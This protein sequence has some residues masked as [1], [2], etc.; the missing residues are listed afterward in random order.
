MDVL[1]QQSVANGIGES[2]KLV[3]PTRTVD[4]AL[5]QLPPDLQVENDG[6]LRYFPKLPPQLRSRVWYDSTSKRLRLKGRFVETPAGVEE[7]V[8]YLLMNVIS[9][10]E[11]NRLV[12][13]SSDSVFKIAAR[14][15]AAA[16]AQPIEVPPNQVF[17][18]LAVTAGLSKGQGYVTL[19]FANSGLLT[20]NNPAEPISLAIFKVECP[21]YRGELEVIVSENPLEE[22]LTLRHSGD[23]AGKPED[24]VFEWRT[25]PPVD[26]LPPTVPWQQ[27]N[28]FVPPSSGIGVVDI[29]IEGPGLFTLSDNWFI[30]RYKPKNSP[31]CLPGADSGDPVGWSQWTTPQLA[32][33]WIKRVMAG[34]NPFEQRFKDYKKTS[35]NTIVSMISQAG[36]RWIGNVPLNQQAVNKSGLIEIYETVLQRGLE[37]SINGSPPVNY[38]PANDALLLAAGRLSDLYMLLGNEA[39]ADAAD[40]TIAFGTDD[41]QYGNVASSLHCFMNQTSSLLEE[42]LKLLRGRDNRLLPSVQTYPFYNRLIWNFTGGMDGGVAAYSLNYNLTD[43]AGPQGVPD[44]VINEWDARASFPQAHGDAWGHYLTALKS[45]YRLLRNPNFTWVPRI[46]AVLVGGVPVSVDYLDERNFAKAAAARA[47]TGAETVN[48]TYRDFYTEDPGGQWKGYK[49]TDSSRA[50]GV[51]EWASRAGQAALFDWAVGNALLPDI[52]PTLTDPDPAND[53]TGIQVIDRRTVTELGDIASAYYQIQSEV[54]NADLGLNPLGLE[55]NTIPFDID[56]AAIE[57]GQDSF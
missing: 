37:L 52:D 57:S 9:Q 20:T 30:C 32:E 36:A 34:I 24:Y 41:G 5:A 31:T 10:S 39:Y 51:S 40:P 16:A 46:E 54:D 18:S 12:A 15:L 11:S 45:Y 19:A 23:F 21:I 27:W 50:W 6:A 48:L 42:E 44:G 35:V 55:K 53:H 56:P 4:V 13:L 17:D 14:S 33:G 8:G 26:G 2:V 47:R 28:T 38:G 7:P 49:D 43:I 29:T 22:K 3:D 25:L 1:Y